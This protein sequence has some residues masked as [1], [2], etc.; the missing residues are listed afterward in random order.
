MMYESDWTD[1]FEDKRQLPLNQGL[2]SV[3]IVKGYK[4]NESQ[5]VKNISIQ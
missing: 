1:R 4:N 2:W 5:G 3:S